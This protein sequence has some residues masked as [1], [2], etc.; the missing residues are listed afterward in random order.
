M[1]PI[2]NVHEPVTLGGFNAACHVPPVVKGG[3]GTR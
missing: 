2:P 3:S 1:V